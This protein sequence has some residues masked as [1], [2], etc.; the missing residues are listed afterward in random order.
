MCSEYISLSHSAGHRQAPVHEPILRDPI[1]KNKDILVTILITVKSGYLIK[2]N[3][4]FL[5]NK[6]ISLEY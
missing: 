1:S 2:I 5:K 6:C 3:Y 4:M